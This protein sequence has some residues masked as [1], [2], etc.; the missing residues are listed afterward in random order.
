MEEDIIDRLEAAI[1]ALALAIEPR[2]DHATLVDRAF[3]ATEVM[4][5][6]IKQIRHSRDRIARARKLGEQIDD[7]LWEANQV[8]HSPAD[9]VASAS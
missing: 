4:H 8:E 6:A 3:D 9:A 7:L 5:E 2:N 1:K